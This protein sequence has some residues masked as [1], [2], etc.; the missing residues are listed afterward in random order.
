MSFTENVAYKDKEEIYWIIFFQ[1]IKRKS[2][3]KQIGLVV[4]YILHEDVFA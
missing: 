2:T 1:N 3:M 4:I